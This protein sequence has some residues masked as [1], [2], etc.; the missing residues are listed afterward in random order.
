VQ[1]EGTN[2]F[3]PVYQK[4]DGTTGFFNSKDQWVENTGT[5]KPFGTNEY[6]AKGIPEGYSNAGGRLRGNSAGTST[7]SGGGAS[8]GNGNVSGGSSNESTQSISSQPGTGNSETASGTPLRLTSSSQQRVN[9]F[10]KDVR[11]AYEKMLGEPS[12]ANKKN[13][14][15]SGN[16]GT[17]N[18]KFRNTIDGMQKPQVDALIN[19]F[20]DANPSSTFNHCPS[21]YFGPRNG[22]GYSFFS[23]ISSG[24]VTAGQCQGD[25][26]S[27]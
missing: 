21:C 27:F 6:T 12:L 5:Y 22:G 20:M 9:S 23:N 24:P 16:W 1:L 17:K 26:C 3:R 13:F 4:P 10:P 7:G 15:Q 8:G 19:N 18:A 25:F 14:L 2:T 11:K